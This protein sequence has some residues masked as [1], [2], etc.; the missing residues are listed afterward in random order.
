MKIHSMTIKNFRGYRNETM[1]PFQDMTV[2]IGKN[3]VGK[4]TILEA[5]DIFFHDGKG[6]V[7]I[8]KTDVNNQEQRYDNLETII[9][10]TFD[11]LPDQI[12]IDATARTTLH[13]EFLLNSERR[14]E[15]IKVFRGATGTPRVFIKA[16]HPTNPVCAGLLLKKN[17]ELRRIVNGQN[18]P[19]ENQAN[20]VCLREAIWRYYQD[21]LQLQEVMI[22]ASKE[23]A[24]AIW[25]KLAVYMPVY[26]LFQSDR[27]NSDGDS[28]VQD[29]LQEAVKEIISDPQLQ[30]AFADIA[31]VVTRKLQEV[32]DRTLAKIREMDPAIATSLN[33]NIPP[34]ST[35]KWAD[36]FKKVSIT[37]D[38][39]IPINKR[40]SGVKRLVLLNFFRAEAERRLEEGNNTGIIYAIE[41]PETSQHS[42]NQKI[43]IQALQTLADMP[44]VQVVLTTHSG[45]IVKHLQFSDLRMVTDVNGQKSVQEIE[46]GVLLYPSLNEVNYLAYGEAVEEYH[47]ELYGFLLYNH[48]LDEYN[49]GREEVLY[50]PLDNNGIP[51]PN[52][53]RITRTEYIRHQIH[54]PENHHNPRFT[55]EQLQESIRAMREFIQTERNAGRL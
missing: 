16:V 8:E 30:A 9:S 47:D 49:Q 29:P 2:F 41:E 19:C 52:P 15:V 54:H 39:D 4:S 37:G 53:W 6:T 21:D 11:D 10:I 48:K 32:S 44:D 35:L 24:K 43:L 26:S 55:S 33:P 51:R 17:N 28:E 5:L 46:P 50:I 40:G 25:E 22:D 7:K 27:K 42:V 36:V 13:S 45:I 18:I 12:V 3:D 31:N 34:A 20:N 1:I 14:L 38:E 23:D